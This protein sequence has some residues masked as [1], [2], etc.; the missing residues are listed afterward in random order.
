MIFFRF[1]KI[2]WKEFDRH[3]CFESASAMA[4][5]TLV[6]LVPLVTVFFSFFANFVEFTELKRK[7]QGRLLMHFLPV[8]GTQINNVISGYIDQ[9]TANTTAVSIFGVAALAATTMALFST[10]ENSFNFI[11]DVKDKRSIV[12][13][14]NAY[15]GILLG[16]PLLIGL[17][18]YIT[19]IFKMKLFGLIGGNLEF[20]QKFYY[21]S[22]P[23]ALSWMAF[24]ISYKVIPHT[25]VRWG[26][27]VAG[28][29]IAG[30]LW[31]IA[32]VAFGYYTT[33]VVNYNLIYGS[34][35]TVPLFLAWL[36]LTWVIVL[37]GM[38]IVCCMQN[39]KSLT[40]Q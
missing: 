9:F 40:T 3:H 15:A 25:P 16:L 32:K 12:K 6:S 2:L 31:E 26:Y 24:A 36:Y 13:K 11:W 8:T 19:T 21:V 20:L 22:V 37:L 1:F 7:I 29:V 35:G 34:L 30:S 14:Y 17:S 28:G 5:V 38:E 4:F 39:F 23:F 27:A 10:V 18:F 33:H